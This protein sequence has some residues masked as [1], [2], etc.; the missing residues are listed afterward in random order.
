LRLA[1]DEDDGATEGYICFHLGKVY[2]SQLDLPKAI[3]CYEKALTIA[4]KAGDRDI[5]ADSYF[6][7]GS[8]YKSRGDLPKAI[9]CL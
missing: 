2:E 7:L 4:G 3:D 5:E 8:A 9:E 1:R 6:R